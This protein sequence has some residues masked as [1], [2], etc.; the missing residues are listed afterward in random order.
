MKRFYF[1]LLTLAVLG[2]GCVNVSTNPES[3]SASDAS[4]VAP[5]T[6]ATEA[7]SDNGTSDGDVN[8]A[9]VVPWWKFWRSPPPPSPRRNLGV[10][11]PPPKP[12]VPG[13]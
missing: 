11:P 10:T 5:E 9:I 13:P 12:P 8:V 3:P 6:P 1:G 2:V 4:A 7:E